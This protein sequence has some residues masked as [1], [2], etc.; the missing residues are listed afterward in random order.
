M[1]IKKHFTGIVFIMAICFLFCVNNK[2]S[3]IYSQT[4]TEAIVIDHNC[5]DLS[6]IPDNW[7]EQAK[8]LKIYFG[9]TSHGEQLIHGMEKIESEKGAKYNMASDWEL[10]N[11]ANALCIRNRSDTY[12]PGDFFP[13][14]PGALNSNPEINVVMYGW[15][16]QP[17]S[18]D[19]QTLL[20]DYFLI[21]KH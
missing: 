17:G 2:N 6:K 5:N 4:R 3:T 19:W 1:G 12:D 16:G 9:H 10:P 20:N 13:T 21:W 7:I 8:K 18:D 11:E 15:C 14:V